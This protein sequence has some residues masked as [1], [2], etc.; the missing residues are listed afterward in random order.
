MNPSTYGFDKHESSLWDEF[1]HFMDFVKYKSSLLD[2]LLHFVDLINM[3]H[4]PIHF[5]DLLN[6]SHLFG[7][8]PSTLWT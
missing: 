1:I 8:N 2:E 7:M 6:I 3:S 4:E 5:M